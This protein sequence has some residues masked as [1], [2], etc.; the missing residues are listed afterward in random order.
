MDEPI[1]KIST[2]LLCLIGIGFFM[3]GPY[4]DLLNYYEKKTQKELSKI[5]HLRKDYD[6][7]KDHLEEQTVTQ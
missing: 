3:E 6:I 4:H 1:L 7:Y 5:E 2:I